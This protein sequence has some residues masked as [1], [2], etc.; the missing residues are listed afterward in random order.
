MLKHPSVLASLPSQTVN[1]LT[2]A[3]LTA[4][5]DGNVISIANMGQRE[6]QGITIHPEGKMKICMYLS[7]IVVFHY[8]PFNNFLFV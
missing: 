8:I 6:F 5:A 3:N 7:Q 2:F 4:L 1:M